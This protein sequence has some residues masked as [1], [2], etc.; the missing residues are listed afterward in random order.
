MDPLSLSRHYRCYPGQGDYPIVDYLDAVTRAGYRGPLSLEIFNDQFR[1]ASAAAIAVDGMR[2]LRAAGEALAARRAARGEAPASRPRRPCRRPPAVERAEFI[3]FAAADADA[4]RA[5]RSVRG[6]RLPAASGATGRRTSTSSARAR[7]T[8]SST[9][10][11]EGFAHAFRLLHGPS[12]CALDA[13]GRFGRQ[14]ARARRARSS[15]RA[16][17]GRIGPGEATLPA[18]AGVEG[19][20]IYFVGAEAPDW[21]DDFEPAEGEAPA[22]AALRA[23]TIS[24]TSCAAANS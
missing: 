22:R 13:Q 4:A 20:L 18:V 9:A 24:P 15:A 2:S 14:G 17:V 5:R 7:S 6:P 21:R 16:Y 10:S 19:S 8:L 1:G 11:S 3:E 12:V 23:S